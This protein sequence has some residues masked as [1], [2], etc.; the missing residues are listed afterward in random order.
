MQRPGPET[1]TRPRAKLAAA[2]N[3][4]EQVPAPDLLPLRKGGYAS[5]APQAIRPTVP[6][7]GGQGSEKRTTGRGAR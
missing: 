2:A 4:H 1:G 7:K 6:K 5:A 3:R